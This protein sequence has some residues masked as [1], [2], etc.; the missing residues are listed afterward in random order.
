MVLKISIIKYIILAI[1][2]MSVGI[3]LAILTILTP[4]T[5]GILCNEYL[6]K[7]I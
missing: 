7:L 3:I 1:S 6:K 2:N 4:M 5:L